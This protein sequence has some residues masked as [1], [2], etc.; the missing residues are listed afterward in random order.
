MDDHITPVLQVMNTGN[1]KNVILHQGEIGGSTLHDRLDIQRDYFGSQVLTLTVKDGT[2]QERITGKALGFVDQFADG[3]Q[4]AVQFV[5][6][7]T[8]D[9]TAD[10]KLV[11]EAVKDSF[12]RH[13]IAVAHLIDTVIHVLDRV[14][15][16]FLT[17]LADH[18]QRTG[19]GIGFKAAGIA[20]KRGKVLVLLHLKTH[21][22]FHLAVDLDQ[23]LISGNYHNVAFLKTDIV[24]NVTFHDKLVD[25]DCSDVPAITDQLDIAQ[26]ADVTHTSRTVKRVKDSG[27]G[28]KG[29]GAR[30][31]H[32]THDIDLDSTD[33]AE[34]QTDVRGRVVRI[35][36]TVIDLV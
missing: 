9:R 27:K 21:R 35:I 22:T 5:D 29:V 2:V 1:I 8:V 31:D 3:I 16:I 14:D 13:N 32:F 30:L 4:P 12:G 11:D 28:G 10:F 26:A 33:A 19:V 18:T 25:V 15:F 17:V 24:L 20:D 23:Y 36:K 7:G 34:C 6:T